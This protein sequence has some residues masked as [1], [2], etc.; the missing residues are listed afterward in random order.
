MGRLE[1]GGGEKWGQYFYYGVPELVAIVN[2]ILSIQ[3]GGFVIGR[4][5]DQPDVEISVYSIVAYL[6]LITY[7][8]PLSLS[9][10]TGIRI[11]NLIGEGD[12]GRVKKVGALY[13]TTQLVLSIIQ[14]IILIGGR[15]V[16]GAVFS[17]DSN[18]ISG[19]ANLAFV[20][21]I[22]HPLD[23]LAIV[24]QG[25]LRGAGKQDIGFFMAFVFVIV[26]YPLS[27]GLSIGMRLVTL[28]YFLGI[29]AG[30]L[31]RAFFCLFIALCCIKWNAFKRVD[32]ESVQ[33]DLFLRR[34]SSQINQMVRTQPC[35]I[36]PPHA[37]TKPPNP[38][39]P[40][41]FSRSRFILMI[42]K[43]IF[44]LILTLLFILMLACKLGIAR[45]SV[46]IEGSYLQQPLEL[47][48]I[49]YIPLRN[50]SK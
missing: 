2:E 50:I 4:I 7:M 17:S 28:G 27:F 13:V 24:F 36:L 14:S 5:S 10:A 45:M 32:S 8:L 42:K 34:R 22:Y 46:Y 1:L 37:D 38:V 25:I 48:C 15:S 31:A 9:T 49:S 39:Y 33:A 30:Y 19:V 29:M 43:L 23:S 20:I 41:Y 16:W 21:T 18:V 12:V 6:D 47:C 44:F 35:I 11:G 26:A 40:I 3:L